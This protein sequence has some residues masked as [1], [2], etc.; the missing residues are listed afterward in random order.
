MVELGVQVRKRENSVEAE[1]RLELV[2]G[3]TPFCEF[4]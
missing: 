3:K 1:L 4:L 2:L